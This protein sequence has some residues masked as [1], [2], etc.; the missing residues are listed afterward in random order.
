VRLLHRFTRVLCLA[1]L[2]YWQTF[3][4]LAEVAVLTNRTPREVIVDVTPAGETYRKIAISSGDSRPVFFDRSASVRFGHQLAPQVYDLE[5]SAAYMFLPE[6]E[7]QSF[8]MERI[9]L[10]PSDSAPRPEVPWTP[11]TPLKKELVTLPIKIAVDDDEP[12]HRTIWEPRLRQRVAEA[13]KVFEQHCGVT[14]SIVSIVTW[15]SDDKIR[16]FGRSMREFEQEVTSAPA[17]LVIGFSSQYDFTTGQIHLGGSR[18]PLYPYILLKER[19]PN[20]RDPE[21]LEL[22]VHEM[23]HFLGASHSPEPQSVMRPVLTIS[24]LRATGARVHFDPVNTLLMSLVADE[25]RRN[26]IH[27]FGDISF[28]TKQ[29][30]LEIYKVLQEALPGDPAA[31]VFQRIV[32]VSNSS[33]TTRNVREILSQ[34]ARMAYL[35]QARAAK[36]RDAGQEAISGDELTARYVREAAAIANELHTP[37]APKAMMLALGLFF[38]D[39]NTLRSFPATSS[40]ATQVESEEQRRNRLGS[41]GD[42]TLRGRE[43]LAKHFFVSAHLSVAMGGGGAR[44]AG[45]LKETL[46]S[47]GGSGFS[48]ADMAANRAGIIFAEKLIAG[49]FTLE[50]ISRSFTVDKFMPEIGDLTEGLTAVSLKSHLAENAGSDLDGE[51]R[52]IER[53]ILELPVYQQSPP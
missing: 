47:H 15:D 51:L 19:A 25:M 21:K 32:G 2:L 33:E 20:V 34:L 12:T 39:S 40:L 43:D 7:G 41:L 29:R 17:Q 49:Q 4:A 31:G 53:R 13:S 24:H 26:Q 6:P 22:L 38:D 37:D 18:G 27:T 16:D 3:P 11:G 28:P 36:G 10:G 23:G 14:L 8:R 46:D 52:R 30:M 48:F 42:P 50:Q 45:L 9:G 5:A 44:S 1:G 35:E